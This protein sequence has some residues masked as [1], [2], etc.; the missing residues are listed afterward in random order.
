MITWNPDVTP[1]KVRV[2]PLGWL[3]AL[4]RGL[5]LALVTYGGLVLL[6]LVRAV[7]WPLCAP[8]RPL[9]PYITQAVCRMAFLILGI[10]YEVRG[11]PMRHHGAIVANHSSW[12]DI[13]A[14]NACQ[15]I[16]FVSKAEVG[17]WPA[18]G[19]LARAT[20]TVFIARDAK[21]AKEQQALFEGRIRA[22][23]R[24]LFF[25]EGTSTDGRRVLPFKST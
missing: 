12:L 10:R 2:A 4:V 9:T 21:E 13:F 6:L 11:Q 1:E 20:G 22:G 3:L 18:I 25:P 16:Y 23:H 8:N 15:R 17:G 5:V 7:E 19:W 24:L 14:L